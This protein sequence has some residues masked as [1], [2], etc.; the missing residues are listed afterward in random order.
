MADVNPKVMDMIRAELEKNP[1]ISNKELFE[2]ATA[3]DKSVGELS[4][5][6]FNARYPLQVKRT[7]RP[8][9]KAAP[10]AGKKAQRRGRPAAAPA[11]AESQAQ[12][13]NRD[14]VRRVM[15]ELARDVANA[16]GKGDVVDVIMGIDGYVDRVIKAAG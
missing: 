11:R 5:R 13:P 4:P 2:K 9:K 14:R 10:R 1:D 3:I 6:Q 7:M 15:L 12:G 8:R 16:Q